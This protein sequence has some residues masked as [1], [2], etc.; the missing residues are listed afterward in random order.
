MAG[1]SGGR[2]MLNGG[3]GCGC[4]AQRT[5]PHPSCTHAWPSPSMPCPLISRSLCTPACPPQVGNYCPAGSPAPIQCPSGTFSPRSGNPGP[6]SCLPCTPGFHCAAPGQGNETG[7]CPAGYYCSGRTSVAAPV[8]AATACVLALNATSSP[9]DPG[10]A[11][12]LAGCQALAGPPVIGGD[13]CPPG[14]RCPVG[15]VQPVCVR[16][17]CVCGVCACGVCVWCVCVCGRVM[18]V[19]GCVRGCVVPCVHVCLCVGVHPL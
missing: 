18:C 14:F 1:G 8:A 7:V 3:C 15:S 4:V 10:W 2:C 16:V 6:A 17:V 9:A 5:H 12:A 11:V 19:P 13:I